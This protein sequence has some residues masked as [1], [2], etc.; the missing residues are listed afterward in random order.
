MRDPNL[1]A[2]PQSAN[3]LSVRPPHG[4]QT[5]VA[6][7]LE[8]NGEDTSLINTHNRST[9]SDQN[10]HIRV[11][12]GR[13]VNGERGESKNH[14]TPP[15]EAAPPTGPVTAPT[16]QVSASGR[17]QALQRARSDLGPRH[18]DDRN[19][20]VVEEDPWHMRHG[21]HEEYSSKAYLAALNSVRCCT[22]RLKE[23]C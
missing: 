4:R 10:G 6:L 22:F 8:A 7:G 20:T 23:A 12:H 9:T 2:N 21:W 16:S 13:D 19:A 3:H 11:V 17:A 15:N 14:A 5:R 1:A 18:R